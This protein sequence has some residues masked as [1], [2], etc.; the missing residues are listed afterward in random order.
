[1]PNRARTVGLEGGQLDFGSNAG[2]LAVH[3]L[4]SNPR[5]EMPPGD[6]LHLLTLPE[7][8]GDWMVSRPPPGLAFGTMVASFT[9]AG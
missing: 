6:A 3:L 8:H 1:M 5:S 9:P 2:P 4:H 7:R